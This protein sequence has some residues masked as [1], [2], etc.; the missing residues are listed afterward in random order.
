[1]RVLN[2][3]VS[4]AL[5]LGVGAMAGAVPTASQAYIGIGI[6][7]NLAPPPLPYYEQPAIP[8]YGYIWTPGYW[9]WDPSVEDY[10]WVPGAWILPPRVGYLWTPAYWGWRDGVYIF[11]SGYWGPHIGFYGGVNYGFGYNGAGYFGGEWRGRNFYYNNSVNNIR[12]INVTNV[13]T[14]NV[15]NYTSVNRVSYAGGPGGVQARPSP[16]QLAASREAHVTA[17]PVQAQHVQA[18]RAQPSQRASINHGAPPIAATARPANFNGPGVVAARGAGPARSPAG[19]PGYRPGAERGGAY[20]GER[21][22]PQQGRAFQPA[23]SAPHPAFAT[24]RPV[25]ERP[26][27]RVNRPYGSPRPQTNV[28]R[29]EPRSQPQFPRPPAPMHPQPQSRPAP[30][31]EPRPAPQSRPAPHEEHPHDERH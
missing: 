22:G 23:Q 21:P 2:S 5:L 1:M 15:T 27:P 14:R 3:T 8:G 29:P 19:A 31:P 25:Q 7:V 10:Y 9:A 13:Y 24:E 30:H 20:G 16:E 6:S 17:T 12:N 18:A 28:S 4:M 11:N 26:S